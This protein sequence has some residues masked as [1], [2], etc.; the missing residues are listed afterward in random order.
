MFGCA[1]SINASDRQTQ[2][3]RAA[4]FTQGRSREIVTRGCD[5][6]QTS[7]K[8][9]TDL[10]ASEPSPDNDIKKR[11]E[12]KMV[13][14]L[15]LFRSVL[16]PES[17]PIAPDHIGQHLAPPNGWSNCNN[18]HNASNTTNNSSNTLPRPLSNQNALIM[19]SPQESTRHIDLRHIQTPLPIT[20]FSQFKLD[21]DALKEMDFTEGPKGLFFKAHKKEPAEKKGFASVVETINGRQ[22]ALIHR[23][24]LHQARAFQEETGLDIPF[25]C[26][27]HIELGKGGEGKVRLAL[28]ITG[29][30][31]CAVKKMTNHFSA[32]KEI[33]NFKL[34]K[35]IPNLI[36]FID[37]AEIFYK[38]DPEK[39]TKT[40][41]TQHYLFM[42]LAPGTNGLNAAF[43]RPQ[44]GQVTQQ[45]LEWARDYAELV[46][47]FHSN[48]LAH[49]DIKPSNF[50]HTQNGI[51]MVDF[52]YITES[53]IAQGCGTNGYVPPNFTGL[54]LKSQDQDNFGLGVSLLCLKHGMTAQQ[55]A[56][57]EPQL[58]VR[59]TETGV[60]S[61]QTVAFP[62]GHCRGI[63]DSQM[64][65]CDTFDGIVARLLDANPLQR[66]SAA[67][68][69]TQLHTL[70]RNSSDK[71]V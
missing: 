25:Q 7:Y 23:M 55:F 50:V 10:R 59:N 13:S 36:Q 52:G 56:R 18:S 17:T 66:S 40:A 29:N 4:T 39:A 47:N 61:R 68:A 14:H 63:D 3:W 12:R 22:F 32:E 71:A 44:K 37:S 24:T 31:W 53:E 67:K 15:S 2:C 60:L 28:D 20:P 45:L 9:R 26:L 58:T 42:T 19:T 54:P 46:A 1:G 11:C 64:Y 6:H 62:G 43:D 41:Q 27:R 21:K 34:V 16:T 65:A 49:Q 51:E 70:I 38:F 48:N 5:P 33:A 30:R 69:F 8:I 35:N 57:S